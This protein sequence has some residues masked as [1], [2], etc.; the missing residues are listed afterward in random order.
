MK[1]LLVDVDSVIPNLAL[2]H[3]STWKKGMGN[4]VGFSIPEPDEVYASC[5][6]KKNKHLVDG[7]QFFYPKA[8]IDVGG[9]GGQFVEDLTEGSRS[10]DARLLNLSRL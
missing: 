8:R 3:I 4:E 6:F 7:L 10:H 9:G 1:T 5:V 2:M